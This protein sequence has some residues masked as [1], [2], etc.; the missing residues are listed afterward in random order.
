[1]PEFAQAP[2][3]PCSGAETEA[4]RSPHCRTCLPS[5]MT[6]TS[7]VA[8]TGPISVRVSVYRSGR[9]HSSVS[10]QRPTVAIM[11][12]KTA[13]HMQHVRPIVSCTM[14]STL[15]TSP[16][17]VTDGHEKPFKV[18]RKAARTCIWQPP[19]S[20]PPDRS[21]RAGACPSCSACQS[22]CSPAGR[23]PRPFKCAAQRS[24]ARCRT[25]CH[26]TAVQRGACRAHHMQCS[27]VQ[28]IVQRSAVR[29]QC[30]AALCA[31]QHSVASV[32]RTAR[33]WSC[34]LAAGAR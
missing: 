4:T 16:A 24:A 23:A 14:H 6:L 34:P 17:R 21:A 11:R 12:V 9:R 30:C 19:S 32:T 27:A 25:A 26:S 10:S 7:A 3:R 22:P 18:A 2:D 20:R 5:L 31:A 28:R 15:A 13:L 29:P 33:P 8:F 1:M